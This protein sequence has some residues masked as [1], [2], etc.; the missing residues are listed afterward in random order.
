MNL[1]FD[2]IIEGD[3]IVQ[4][5]VRLAYKSPLR[6]HIIDLALLLDI[7]ML[8]VVIWMCWY[9]NYR[10]CSH[11]LYSL[12]KH[13][14]NESVLKYK[15]T[16]RKPGVTW[17]AILVVRVI[18]RARHHCEEDSLNIWHFKGSYWMQICGELRN[19][20]LFVHIKILWKISRR[21]LRTKVLDRRE[22]TC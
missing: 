19:L 16:Y 13:F 14:N 6:K 2:Y 4:D 1:L 18:T 9:T 12:S 5:L 21:S 7:K 15:V 22:A 11:G 17:T 20:S 8:R 3:I 10:L